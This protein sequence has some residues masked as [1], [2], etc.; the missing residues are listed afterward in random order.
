MAL[1]CIRSSGSATNLNKE[2]GKTR[3]V[4]SSIAERSR[5]PEK[6]PSLALLVAVVVSDGGKTVIVLQSEMSVLLVPAFPL[7]AKCKHLSLTRQHMETSSSIGGGQGEGMQHGLGF[8]P[9][10]HRDNRAWCKIIR[11]AAL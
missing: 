5:M 3:R 9:R 6:F 10:E 4:V 8:L 1:V 11:R 2:V 7:D